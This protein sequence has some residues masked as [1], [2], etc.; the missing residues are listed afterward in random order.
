MPLPNISME[1][2][3]RMVSIETSL[4]SDLARD[5]RISNPISIKSIRHNKNIL[6][7]IKLFIFYPFDCNKKSP[8][9][10]IRK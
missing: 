7:D 1:T 4:M 5:I 2:L 3:Y 8:E 10:L 9:G 6:T